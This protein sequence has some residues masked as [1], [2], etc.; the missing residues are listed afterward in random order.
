[1]T[2]AARLPID[3]ERI[4][5]LEARVAECERVITALAAVFGGGGAGGSDVAPDRDL[6]STRGDEKIRM[7]PRDWKGEAQ[8]GRSMSR[9]DP[10][11]LEMYAETM[12]YF[13]SKNTDATRAGYDRKAAARARGWARRLLA[14]WTPPDKPAPAGN[15]FAP[16]GAAPSTTTAPAASVV[17]R[18]PFAPAGP[19]PA[20]IPLGPSSLARPPARVVDLD[21]PDVQF[22]FGANLKPL[23]DTDDFADDDFD[24]EAL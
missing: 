10:A 1:M 17:R 9:C 15:P 7:E 20:P 4:A 13:A 8:K 14:G 2:A 5:A 23:A 19:A 6:D 21:D 24:D 22:D 3:A 11:F 12:D 16:K 18:N